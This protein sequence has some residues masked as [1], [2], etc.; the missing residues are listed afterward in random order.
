M[1]H[2]DP[3]KLHVT[4]RRGARP[5]GLSNPRRYTLTHSDLTGDLY[6]TI[7][8][9]YDRKQVSGLY[10]RLMRDEVLAEWIAGEDGP[11]LH[12]YCHVSG[13]LVI[14]SPAWR[15]A[16]FQKHLPMV[17][18]AFCLGDRELFEVQPELEGAPAIVHF[19]A[20]HKRYRR[21]EDWGPLSA[22]QVHAAV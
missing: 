16:I 6:L 19:H 7:G 4:L 8:M 11:A 2:L 9:S 14:G 20:R 21:Q 5:P 22:Y 3:E 18:E 15:Y 1:S 10:T 12:T 17:V 13:G